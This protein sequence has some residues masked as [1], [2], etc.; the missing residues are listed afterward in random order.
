MTARI[1]TFLLFVSTLTFGQNLPDAPQPKPAPKHVE[2]FVS[3]KFSTKKKV[4][5]V[6]GIAAVA[7]TALAF[8]LRGGHKQPAMIASGTFSVPKK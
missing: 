2:K 5:A 7:A 3:P 4:I 8:S 1:L 6:S